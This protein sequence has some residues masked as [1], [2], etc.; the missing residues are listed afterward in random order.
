VLEEVT[1][2]ATEGETETETVV[3]VTVAEDVVDCTLRQRGMAKHT[4]AI[5]STVMAFASLS[6]DA[7]LADHSAT[8]ADYH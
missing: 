7:P 4:T 3:A 8:T 6:H 5:H 2:D 1:V